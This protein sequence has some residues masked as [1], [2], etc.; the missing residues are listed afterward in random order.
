M[1]KRH[2]LVDVLKDEC[3][4]SLIETLKDS[5]KR[6]KFLKDLLLQAVS[7]MLERKIKVRCLPE[8]VEVV[9]SL[10]AECEKEYFSLLRA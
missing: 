6:R 10:I 4:E 8:D 3:I 9:K 1:T 2:H 5:G 7:K